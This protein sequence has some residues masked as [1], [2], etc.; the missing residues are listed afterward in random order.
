MNLKAFQLFPKIIAMIALIAILLPAF[1]VC[2]AQA[3]D[4]VDVGQQVTPACGNLVCET[5]ENS[6]NCPA[7]CPAPPVPPVVFPPTG[8]GGGSGSPATI[9]DLVIAEIT[10]T[11]AKI[12]W[13]TVGPA[14]CK[15]SWGQT[16][17]YEKE[18]ISGG[19][20]DKE[21]LVGLKNLSPETLYYFKIIC[22]DLLKTQAESGEQQF[23][24]LFRQ[25]ITP[26]ANVSDFEATAEEERIILK[27][28]NPSDPDLA[29]V[30]ILRSE[31]FYPSDPWNGELVYEGKDTSFVD[32]QV[33][34]GKKYYYTAF[35]YDKSGNYSSGAVTFAIPGKPGVPP[36]IPPEVPPE[37]VP[38]EI[39]KLSIEDFD[40]WQG[41]KKV[42]LKDGKFILEKE[43]PL[44]ISIN[45]EK[46]PEVLKTIMV[47]IEK[48]G[49]KG[50]NSKY[51]SFLLRINREKT[52]YEAT[53][54]PPGGGEIFPFSINILDYKNQSFK[55]IS[56]QLE[57]PK[58][59]VSIN[60][61]PFYKNF[62]NWI[63]LL[64]LSIILIA[65]AYIILRKNRKRL[66]AIAYEKA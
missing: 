60:P 22:Q 45:Y 66:T 5:G 61:V 65:V 36:E 18:I 47:T 56:G 63:F 30:R 54:S 62:K 42:D 23:K 12:S 35:T 11:S 13:K 33:A 10:Q 4:A 20:F 53:I 28:Q 25:D 44:K 49:Q 41:G 2:R 52:A 19:S 29:G 43:K 39:G 58:T 17:D 21:H 16:P 27:W 46:V 38:P 55:K 37:L 50:E 14:L 6:T 59:A 7:D 64:I 51:F 3:G 34:K 8:P 57:F 15:F 26:P 24:T 1:E 48:P 40:F 9:Y 31:S 32:S